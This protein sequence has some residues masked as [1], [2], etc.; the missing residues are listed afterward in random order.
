MR[1][2]PTSWWVGLLLFLA[3]PPL[4]AQTSFALD[5]LA[6]RLAGMTA[7]TGYEQRM[8]DSLL[9][10]VPGARRDRAGNVVSGAGRRLVVCPL[11]EPGWVVGAVRPDGYLRLRRSPGRAPVARDAQLEGARVT[12]FGRAGGVPGV[13]AVRSIHLTRGREEPGGGGPFTADSAYVDLGA[14]SAA[15]V[16]RLGVRTLAVVA[17][18]KRPHRYGRDLVAVPA[19]G[20]RMACAAVLDVALRQPPSQTVVA[21]TVEHEL[22]GRGLATVANG[23]GPFAE[24]LIVDGAGADAAPVETLARLGRVERLLLPVRHA[25]TPVESVSLGDVARLRDEVAAWLERS[26]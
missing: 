26:P 1:R 6:L 22:L 5:T 20:R 16:E 17:P 13:V 7:V 2:S 8:A 18:A 19:A 9:A 14:S 25:G 23:R 24:T 4:P 21:F 3:V 15:E 12:I 11:D 10:L